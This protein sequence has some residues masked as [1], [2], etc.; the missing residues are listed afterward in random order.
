MICRWLRLPCVIGLTTVALG[1]RAQQ[2]TPLHTFFQ[3]NYDSTIIYQSGLRE[4]FGPAYQILAKHQQQVYL[5]TYQSPYRIARGRYF[6]GNLVRHFARQESAFRATEPD[7]NRYLLPDVVPSDTLR[8]Y[9]QRLRP[10][11]LWAIKGDG[12]GGPAGRHCVIDD[13]DHHTFYLIDRRGIRS[14][15]FYAPAYWEACLGHNASRQQALTTIEVFGAIS[16]VSQ[17]GPR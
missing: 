7:T 11:R 6:P 15:G 17:P 10:R 12:P 16:R 14:A 1:S 8:R 9:W 13:G 5:F 2:L 3:R 4:Q